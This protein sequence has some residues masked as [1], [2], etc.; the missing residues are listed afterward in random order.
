MTV[1]RTGRIDAV[2]GHTMRIYA[3]FGGSTFQVENTCK[4]PFLPSWPVYMK[5]ALFAGL[6]CCVS[7]Q[8]KLDLIRGEMVGG[9][10][11]GFE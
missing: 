7:G 10:G 5:G 3:V 1:S 4:C 8:I 2:L 9:G 11:V 6:P